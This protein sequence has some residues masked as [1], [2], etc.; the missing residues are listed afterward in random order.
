MST[1]S[2]KDLADIVMKAYNHVNYL[3][4]V[5]ADI[6]AALNE[7]IDSKQKTIDRLTKQTECKLPTNVINYFKSIDNASDPLLNK[8]K[9]ERIK[10]P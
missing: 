9:N 6:V 5:H 3:E 2:S 1:L 8:L 7:D 10:K 4:K